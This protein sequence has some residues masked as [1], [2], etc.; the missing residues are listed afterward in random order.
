MRILAPLLLVALL[1]SAAAADDPTDELP[2]SPIALR[3]W[4]RAKKLFEKKSYE[5]ATIELWAGYAIEPRRAFLFMW[6]QAERLNGDCDTATV[7]YKE[8]LAR[9]PPARQAD[10]TREVLRLCQEQ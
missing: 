9:K 10:Y 6:G 8:F 1:A 2:T 3:H 4:N 5:A 7:L